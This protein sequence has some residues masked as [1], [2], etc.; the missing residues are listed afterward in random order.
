MQVY[1]E[2]VF[3]DE[4]SGSGNEDNDSDNPDEEGHYTHDY[5]DEQDA[6]SNDSSRERSNKSSRSSEEEP[7]WRDE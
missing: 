1:D 2:L 6:S 5:P 4:L 3:E 7:D